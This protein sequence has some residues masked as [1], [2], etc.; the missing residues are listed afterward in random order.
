M[1]SGI[2][3]GWHR[4]TIDGPDAAKV[5]RQR[6]PAGMPVEEVTAIIEPVASALDYAHRNGLLHR[7][8]KP[9]NIL[10]AAPEED[11]Q[12]CHPR[13]SERVRAIDLQYSNILRTSLFPI[14]SWNR[15]LTPDYSEDL[16]ISCSNLGDLPTEIARVDGTAAE[17]V[18]IRA[19]DTNVTEGEL[20][21]SHGQLVVV[22]G[23][24]NGWVSISVEGY[25]LDAENSRGETARVGPPGAR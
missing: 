16:P 15:S 18:L 6:Y 24:I 9:A 19:L 21:R 22:S 17:Y 2:K 7:D 12:R 10:L 8:V 14:E 4:R 5:L 20:R 23:R 11:G 25:Q 1:K 3:C 13:C